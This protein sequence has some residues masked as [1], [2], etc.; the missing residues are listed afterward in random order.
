MKF[1]VTCECDLQTMT[2]SSGTTCDSFEVTV[3][4][5]SARIAEY[6][7][8]SKYPGILRC[9]ATA[10]SRSREEK[11]ELRTDIYRLLGCAFVIALIWLFA[12]G[13]EARTATG[14]MALSLAAYFLASLL[15]LYLAHVLWVVVQI[16]ADERERDI[17]ALERECYRRLGY[18]CGWSDHEKGAE[19]LFADWDKE[20][21]HEGW[22]MPLGFRDE[23]S[24]LSQDRTN[25][26]SDL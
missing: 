26:A 5:A 19:P 24:G 13:H 2:R 16:K 7:V 10:I 18:R 8:L 23:T 15:G 21:A 20:E 17:A 25:R 11:R 3:D 9:N 6:S 1:L 12:S 4:A 14:D 22:S